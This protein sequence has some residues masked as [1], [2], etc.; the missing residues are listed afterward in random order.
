MLWISMA[1]R[2]AAR[3]LIIRY[4]ARIT[5]L[6]YELLSDKKKEFPFFD[7]LLTIS[8]LI[9]SVFNLRHQL[10]PNRGLNTIL[11]HLKLRCY[12][13]WNFQDVFKMKWPAVI[14][15]KMS[16]YSLKMTQSWE[17]S[18]FVVFQR[19]AMS[20]TWCGGAYFLKH[21]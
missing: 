6:A 8:T 18:F 16:D 1:W 10:L 3:E 13:Q 19:N 21:K 15:Q 17:T 9:L 2:G 20:K 7:G 5:T 11:S 12:K 14:F 4:I